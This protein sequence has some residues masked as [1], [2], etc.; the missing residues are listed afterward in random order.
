MSL[1][2]HRLKEVMDQ[3]I[4]IVQTDGKAFKGKLVEFD[5]N[6]ILLHDCLETGTKDVKWRSVMVPIPSPKDKAMRSEEGGFTYG[7]RDKK[8]AILR[9]VMINLQQVMRMWLWDPEEYSPK[10]FEDMAIVT[11]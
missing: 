8:V 10:E 11:L 9:K 3:Q 4:L 1:I 5:D 6:F 7:E 2:Q